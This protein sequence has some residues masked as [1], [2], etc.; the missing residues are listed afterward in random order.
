MACRISS[1]GCRYEATVGI[2]GFDLEIDSL[3]GAA[4]FRSGGEGI[5]RS[6]RQGELAGLGFGS[7]VHSAADPGVGDLRRQTDV[8][9]PWLSGENH[10]AFAQQLVADFHFRVRLR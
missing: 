1:R 9:Q 7:Q 10:L 2:S 3:S 4:A 6:D 8:D 5:E